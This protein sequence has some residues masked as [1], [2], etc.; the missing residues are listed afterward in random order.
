MGQVGQEIYGA[1][2]PFVLTARAFHRVEGAAF[3]LYCNHLLVA[4]DRTGERARSLQ[5]TGGETCTALLAVVRRGRTPLPRC[6][7]T[8]AGGDSVRPSLVADDRI[9]FL[10][11]ATARAV[12][13]WSDDA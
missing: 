11:P 10:L 6:K 12:L 8:L 2:A 4:Q 1:G 9:E 7:L 13:T 3:E 5:L